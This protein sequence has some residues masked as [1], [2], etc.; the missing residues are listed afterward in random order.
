MTSKLTLQIPVML[1]D[2]FRNKDC[3]NSQISHYPWI[4][5]FI[6]LYRGHRTLKLRHSRSYCSQ[7]EMEVLR[8]SGADFWDHKALGETLLTLN[9]QGPE[10]LKCLAMH[11]QTF[12]PQRTMPI[13]SPMRNI[14]TLKTRGKIFCP[15]SDN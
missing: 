5:F 3:V 11:R 8:Q 14:K 1:T 4:C 6:L 7:L 9:G 2:Y 13:V 10:I 15:K 12:V